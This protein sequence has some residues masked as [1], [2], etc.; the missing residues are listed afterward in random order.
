MLS[1]IELAKEGKLE[2]TSAKSKLPIKVDGV[3]SETL[4]VYKIP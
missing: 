2:K 4:D 3:S 1:L